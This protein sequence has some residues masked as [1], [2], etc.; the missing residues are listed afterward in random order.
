[1]CGIFGIVLTAA[2][3]LSPDR[4]E[5]V[6]RLLFRISEPR[7]REAAGCAIAGADGIAVFKRPST[8]SKM[9]KSPDFRAFLRDALGQKGEVALLGHCRLVTSG[10]Q[11]IQSHN[12][13]IVTGDIV[14]VHNGIIVNADDLLPAGKNDTDSARLFHLIDTDEGEIPARI[15]RAYE[16]MEGEASIAFLHSARRALYLATNTGS[17]YY[18][19]GDGVC[20]FA[21]ER[22]F[23][24]TFLARSGLDGL[25]SDAPAERLQPGH[26]AVIG[27]SDATA[28]SF[29][30]T[31]DDAVTAADVPDVPP[32]PVRDL[33]ICGHELRRCSRCILPAT[34]PLIEFDADGVCNYCREYEPQ[35][36]HGR[37]ALE[38]ILEC[39]RSRDGSP[40]C[41][42]AFS[43][44]RDSSYGLHLLKR[45]LGMNPIA[46]S[47]DWGLVT[48]I[49]RR[50][51]SRM[52]ARLGV[53][54]IVRAADIPKKRRHVRKNVLAWLKRPEL[55]MVPLF[56]AGDKMFFHHAREIRKQTGIDLVVFSA[57]NE[58]ERTDFK[59]GFLGVRENRHRQ[60]LFNFDFGVKV[61]MALWYAKQY[62]LN[63]AYF[64][65]SFFD[66]LFAYYSTF[67]GRDDFLYLYHYLP[68]DEET[69]NNTLIGE[70]GWETEPGSDNTWRIGDGY[71]AFINYIYHTVAGFSE[72]D[73]FRSNQIREG[74]IDRDEALRLAAIDNE[75]KLENIRAFTEAVGLNLEELLVRINAI[76]KLY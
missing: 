41:I 74:L 45:E 42:V 3:A 76:P 13:P 40:D 46:Y 65:E 49:A 51:Q 60:V 38:R 62:L 75:P 9:L 8:P 18:A 31:G 26:G 29:F 53:E 25:P 47:Y 43:G 16:R 27:F 5:E 19:V 58:L 68:W 30:L 10:S 34:Y 73:T 56:M 1:M 64:N 11:V 14:G 70:Y 63:P 48:D 71:T 50:N 69:I 12:Q 67:I 17:L 21:S 39:H 23:V 57:G 59:T 54:H 35:P 61:R 52:C 28:H 72:Y 2:R 37:E 32:L 7:G 20:V 6:T 22:Y 24:E 55:G 66:S 33:T 44:G 4:M 36:L 15:A